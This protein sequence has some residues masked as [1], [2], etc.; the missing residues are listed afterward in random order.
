MKRFWDKVKIVEPDEC[1]EWQASFHTTGYGQI[2]FNSKK[3]KAHRVSW[4][5]TNGQIPVGLNVC[6]TCDN[7]K[8]VNPNHLWLGT[9]KENTQD[10]L[11][12]KRGRWDVARKKELN[13]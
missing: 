13:V 4:I 6:H 10:M 8:C 5:L 11:T 12:K 3:W 1:W 7:R 2:K 9:L